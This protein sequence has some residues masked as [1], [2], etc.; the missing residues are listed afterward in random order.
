MFFFFLF[1]ILIY[2]TRYLN[3]KHLLGRTKT[4]NVN[5]CIMSSLRC[6]VPVRL[7]YPTNVFLFHFMIPNL[8]HF[9]TSL[10][11][12]TVSLPDKVLLKQNVLRLFPTYFTR[13]NKNHTK[14]VYSIFWNENIDWNYWPESAHARN[15]F[16]N[17][18]DN[19]HQMSGAG[20]M[21]HWQFWIERYRVL[22]SNYHC[23]TNLEYLP[24]GFIFGKINRRIFHFK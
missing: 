16:F 20:W 12:G 24:N 19:H 13:R 22:R 5:S 15:E 6:Y 10:S 7:P 9:H 17:L 8:F 18:R 2:S 1:V 23:T 21:S 3:N 4:R 11:T 14:I